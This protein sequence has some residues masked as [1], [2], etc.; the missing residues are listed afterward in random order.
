MSNGAGKGIFAEHA[1]IQDLFV[2][3]R[4]TTHDVVTRY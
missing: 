1:E 3:A 4:V 2:M